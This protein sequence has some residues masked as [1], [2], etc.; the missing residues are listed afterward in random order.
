MAAAL[1]FPQVF[2]PD[3]SP[4]MATVSSFGT[5]AV[6]FFFRPLGAV[7]FGHFGDRLGRKKTLVATL[8]IMGLSTIAIGLLPSAA[9]IGALAPA[10]LILLRAL[11]GF[12]VGGEWSGAVL[13][14]AEYAPPKRRGAFGV[15]P[16]IGVG[17]GLV[18]ASLVFFTISTVW[19]SSEAML[20]WAWRI[21]FLFSI[22]LVVV[23]LYTRLKVEETPV[24]KMRASTTPASPLTDVLKQ[25][26]RR[27]LLA[28][29]AMVSIFTFTFM[30]GTYL[31]GYG[32]T[33]LGHSYSLVLIANV[34]G[35]VGMVVFCALSAWLS[36]RHG[37]RKVIL[38]GLALSVPWAPA[39]L[40]LLN[41]GN[42]G[43]FIV[44]IGIT[45][46]VMAITYGPM[47]AFIP[48]LFSTGHRYTGAG[49]A[50]NLAGVVGGALPPVVAGYLS[51]Q[52]GVWAIAALLILAV[53]V[54]LV[55]VLALPETS[56]STLTAPDEH[57]PFTERHS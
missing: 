41:T 40:P 50:Y 7:F 34:V 2:F 20:N 16:Q 29:G 37:R 44:T 14:T 30:G 26:P 51:A 36:D 3:L 55:S 42:P 27:V 35:G 17:S 22:V 19:G 12:A 23:A 4:T 10:L 28:S 11:Q 48:E 25:Q 49:L 15:F 5:F 47:A 33:E 21:P 32:R 9:T 39:V 31:T 18:L 56:N 24:F 1:V 13:L 45:F 6:A 52:L 46:A 54:S 8:L 53:V 57:N 38:V 43:L